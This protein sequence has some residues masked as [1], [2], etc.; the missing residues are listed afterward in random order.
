MHTVPRIDMHTVPYTLKVCLSCCGI[1][2]S[3]RRL[4]VQS[5]GAPRKAEHG[6]TK[7]QSVIKGNVHL[8]PWEKPATF[9]AFHCVFTQS[10]FS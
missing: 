5:S 4:H 7:V 10:V 6:A 9:W 8:N 3:L 1:A 2:A